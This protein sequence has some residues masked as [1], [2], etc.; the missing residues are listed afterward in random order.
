MSDISIPGVKG[1][2]YDPMVEALMK[3]ERVPRDRTAE[4]LEQYQLQEA[5]WRQINRRSNEVKDAARDLY[6]FNSPFFEKIAESTNDRV[7]TAQATR[8]AQEQKF[9][10]RI[11]QVADKD[12]FLSKEITK[13]LEVPSGLYTFKVGEK[14]VSV[15][16]RGGSYRSFADTVNKRA[17]NI[18]KI[19]EIKTTP[20]TRALLFEAQAE[21]TE[22]ALVFED[23]AL[24]LALSLDMIKK[25]AGNAVALNQTEITANPRS[26][27]KIDFSQPIRARD[28]Y[29]LEFTVTLQSAADT[30]SPALSTGSPVFE[31]L[32]R[33]LFKGITI[34]NDPSEA[35]LPPP[36]LN[37]A[38]SKSGDMNLLSL[39]STRGVLIPLPALAEGTQTM[40]IS[41]SEYG[42]VR[43]LHIKN[44]N[45]DAAVK[46]EGVRIFDPLAQ[47][48]YVP[49]HAV[50]RAQDAVFL[51]EGIQITR[52]T[53]SIDD[54]VA[55]VTLNLHDVSDKNEEITVKPD[56]EAVKDVLITF[57]GKY[58]RLLA[59]INILTGKQPAIIEELAYFTE[60]EK[61]GAKKNLGL[62]FG[63]SMLSNYKNA[64]R[65][66]TS[67]VYRSEADT[68]IRILSQI[69]ISTNTGKNSGI[70]A[71]RLRGYLEIDE[72]LLD[73]ALE[74]NFNDVKLL[75]GYDGDGDIIID[76][77][78]GYAVFSQ[79]DPYVSRGGIFSTR[80]SGLAARIRDTTKRLEN[81]DKKLAK[82]E[83]ELRRKY[84][85]M[86]GTLKKLKKQSDTISG[87]NQQQKKE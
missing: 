63:D 78:I 69:G 38:S 44:T 11:N 13:D 71:S 61:D 58:N 34:T 48:E 76:S 83:E 1:G 79:I 33:V 62:L 16:W 70:D 10:I 65:Q 59:E 53:N 28:E 22:N 80:T 4:Q 51:F 55:G 72:K 29:M 54:L 66:K 86:E 37:A 23:D 2:T 15:K 84:G 64:L 45:A 43:S 35:G 47:G 12:S 5:A 3:V 81:Y 56:R 74:D 18:V 68:P 40:R 87:F 8:E 27:A 9:R 17:E 46:L 77:G 21:G 25:N 52:P 36:S 73:A 42:D 75:F 20:K 67:D 82:K 41:L 30:N 7:I 85:A 14:T 24:D 26:N 6:S 50:S 57:V 60:D 32:G 49:V 39:E 31:Q 19:T